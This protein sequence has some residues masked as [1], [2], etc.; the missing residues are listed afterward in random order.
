MAQL[1]PTAL[2]RER[3]RFLHG[4][5]ERDG[6]SHAVD[7]APHHELFH[8]LLQADY[9]T[10]SIADFDERI[11]VPLDHFYRIGNMATF[12]NTP[13]TVGSI[14]E[15]EDHLLIDA[16]ELIELL[17]LT[18]PIPYR[19]VLQARM[20]NFNWVSIPTHEEEVNRLTADTRNLSHERQLYRRLI[21]SL[22]TEGPKLTHITPL[23]THISR[24]H[25]Q[26]DGLGRSDTHTDMYPTAHAYTVY[27]LITMIDMILEQNPNTVI[28]IQS[29]HGFH[30]D[31]IQTQLLEDGFS[32]AEVASLQNSVMSAVRIPE[33]YG[34]LDVPLN[35]LNITRELVNRF[36]GP[37]Y[38]LL[39]E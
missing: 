4:A 6:I 36:V 31:D 12:D 18:T 16:L 1:S 2:R 28:V 17:T 11:F 20:G 14:L 15:V 27:M 25:W 38:Q 19:F 22:S 23:F 37:N 39:P 29:D 13:F 32:E 3:R 34:G 26:Y 8:A 5:F 33:Q 7:I 21:D 10:I 9:T 35:P 30:L 24:W